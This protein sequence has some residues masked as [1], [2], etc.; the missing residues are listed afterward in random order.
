MDFYKNLYADPI[1]NAHTTSSS[2]EFIGTL[3]PSMVSSEENIMLTKCP[4]DLEIKIVVFNL[5]GNSVPSP[6]GFGGVFYHSC[7]EII[8]KDVCKVV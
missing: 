5:N 4:D 2:E 8:G 6:N 7:W 1:S 3:I